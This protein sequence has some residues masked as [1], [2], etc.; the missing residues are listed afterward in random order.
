MIFR[1]CL[2]L[3]EPKD[4]LPAILNQYRE[5]IGFLFKSVSAEAR[6]QAHD[7]IKEVAGIDSK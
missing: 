6:K 3:A 4:Q 7:R 1:L 5:E 2:L